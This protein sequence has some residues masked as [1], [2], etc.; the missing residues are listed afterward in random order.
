M[1][2]RAGLDSVKKREKKNLSLPEFESRSENSWP[3]QF[4]D[5]SEPNSK[6]NLRSNQR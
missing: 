3:E 1:N 6:V 5:V 2:L 4:E